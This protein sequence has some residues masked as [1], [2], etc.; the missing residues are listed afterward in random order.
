[1]LSPCPVI[2][3]VRSQDALL[4]FMDQAVNTTID[5]VAFHANGI[6]TDV[7]DTITTSFNDLKTDAF[8]KLVKA[9]PIVQVLA[10]MAWPVIKK[11]LEI[12]FAKL[13]QAW[14]LCESSREGASRITA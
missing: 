12:A 10:P 13:K 8:K 2:C 4:L 3:A 11:V 7:S 1:M 14:N 6:A 9:V 5:T